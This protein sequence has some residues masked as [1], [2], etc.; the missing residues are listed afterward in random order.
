MP[1]LH[2]R[3][4]R[5]GLAVAL[6]AGLSACAQDAPQDTWDPAGDNAQ[7]IHDLQ[8]PIFLVAGIVGV[9][10]VVVVVLAIFKFK[11]RGQPI[12]EQSHG[13]PIIEYTF[14]ALPAA[15][16]A[17][18]AGF[19]VNTILDLDETAD[20]ECVI[21]VT[22]QQWWWEYD[23]P[24]AADGS[25]CGFAPSTAAAAPLITS[26]QVVIPADTKVLIRGTSRDVIHSY[27]IPRLN[28][29][30]DMVPGRVHTWRF[31]AD[32]PGIYAGQCTEFCGLSHANM[33]MEMVALNDAD[34]QVWL[35]NQLEPYTSPEA[36]TLAAEG[37]STF[38]S[39]CSRCHQ[40][41]GL[42]DD[43][44]NDDPSDDAP[45]VAAPDQWV[46]SGAAPN[47]TNLMTRNTFA[48]ASW[49]LLTPECRADV[50]NASPDEF[51]AAYLKGVTPECLNE[52]DLKEWLR[53]AP[54][55]KPMYADATQLAE[56]DGKYRGM[57]ALGLSEDQIDQLVAYLLERK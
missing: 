36:G 25:I 8:W 39:Q 1:V 27:W 46:Y 43:K 44:G 28:G 47:L 11:D 9:I 26:G 57:P 34:F 52:V 17:V 50:W 29:K 54:S 20:T 7:M 16:L 45:V 19:T 51:G 56:T 24:V 41:D 37:E 14:I 2:R 35:D 6:L 12:P 49:D 31:E 15:L 32:E 40:V 23:Y 5:A 13:N 42:I 10:V 18:I 33:R 3:L 30:R 22:G 38:I 48:G 55:K 21:N 53:D 4:T